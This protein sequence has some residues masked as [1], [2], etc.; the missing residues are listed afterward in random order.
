MSSRVHRRL[1]LV[2]REVV[3][4]S[5]VRGTAVSTIAPGWSSVA[6]HKA[7][8]GSFSVEAA[9]RAEVFGLRGGGLSSR[10]GGLER[11]RAGG[12]VSS[13]SRAS[14]AL[15]SGFGNEAA[16]S[17]GQLTDRDLPSPGSLVLPE[18]WSDLSGSDSNSSSGRNRCLEWRAASDLGRAA[19][20]SGWSESQGCG[21]Q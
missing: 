21:Q 9:R 14:R 2:F 18:D 15:S 7:V 6:T 17:G 4:A 16:H 19:P 12:R 10:K 3:F 11:E 13:T 8:G 1:R 20:W 5:P